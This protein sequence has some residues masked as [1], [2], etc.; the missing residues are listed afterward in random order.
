VNQDSVAGDS[1]PEAAATAAEADAQ[2]AG[3]GG[4]ER[5]TEDG[6]RLGDRRRFSWKTILHGLRNPRRRDTRRESDST[7]GYVDFHRRHLLVVAALILCFSF[8]DGM[9]SIY[10]TSLGDISVGSVMAGLAK[11][12]AAL[13]ALLKWGLTAF[14]VIAIIMFERA[15]FFGRIRGATLLYGMLIGYGLLVAY[16]LGLSWMFL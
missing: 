4:N 5:R 7:T 11:Q 13:L 8:M 10:L 3:V 12:D 1:I 6:A 2:S 16:G 9:I 15:R 14:A